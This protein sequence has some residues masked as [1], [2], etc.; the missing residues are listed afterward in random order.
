VENALSWRKHPYH[1]H[2][3]KHN[4]PYE[5]EFANEMFVVHG[6]NI[7]TSSAASDSVYII[8]DVSP[9]EINNDDVVTVTFYS[10][11]PNSQQYGDWIGAYSPAN[12]DIKTTSPVKFGWCDEDPDFDSTGYGSLHFN[13]TNLRADVAFYYFT[14][15]TYYPVFVNVSTQNVTFV[16]NNQPLRPRVVA[17]GDYDVFNLLWSSA[18]STE[19]TMQWGT[20][21]GEYVNVVEAVTSTIQKSDMFGYP[22]NSSGWRDLGLIHT[23]PM[24]GMMALAN[25]KIYYKFG[26][27]ATDDYSE[28]FVF[29]V[30]PLPGKL[31]DRCPIRD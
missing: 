30:P 17:T 10:N 7:K 5:T 1:K 19:P 18:S 16:N 22:A 26:D 23:A 6:E 29:N 27:E 4:I 31:R 20:N 14:S 28:E 12:S 25:S 2:F 24:T 13:L 21:P 9:T 8:E 3:G 11:A 15:G